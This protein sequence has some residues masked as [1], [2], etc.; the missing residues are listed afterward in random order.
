MPKLGLTMQE[1]L[2]VN[3][4]KSEGDN[5][6]K[7]ESV[8]EIETE[9][10]TNVVESPADGVLLRI[11]CAPGDSLPIASVLAYLGEAGEAVPDAQAAREEA[12]SGGAAP[13]A[14]PQA[15]GSYGAAQEGGGSSGMW[16]FPDI[17]GPGAG[18][19]SDP[20]AEWLPDHDA[21]WLQDHDA[22]GSPAGRTKASPAARA[23]AR[24]YGIDYELLTGTGPGGRIIREDVLRHCEQSKTAGRTS[25][26]LAVP[27]DVV[28]LC[29]QK[30]AAGRE[31]PGSAI[32]E[33]AVSPCGQ[34]EASPPVQKTPTEGTAITEAV[35]PYADTRKL[36]GDN[37][38]H[39]WSAI[40]MAT[41]HVKADIS[42]LVN[43][44]AQLNAGAA[45][46]AAKIGLLELFA[47]TV[48]RTI[49]D[50]PVFNSS[51]TDAGIYLHE[52]IN[53]GIAVAIRGG[54]VIPVVRD[55]GRKNI[56]TLSREIKSLSG[57]AAAGKLEPGDIG[58][59]TFTI[60]HIGPCGSVDFFTPIIN[61]PESAIL[62]IGRTVETPVVK[63]G[64]I[65]IRSMTGLSL[66]FDHRV[67]DDAPA[68]EFLAAL[69]D[70]IEQPLRAVF[71]LKE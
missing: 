70:Y 9:K 13:E 60:S 16:S 15:E 2:I 22:D 17:P 30:E 19:A 33:D 29:E 35:I 62:G 42:E 45:D 8:F 23:L 34:S 68:A 64:V 11:V 63:D 6:S 37:M 32:S 43:I 69:L 7:G 5:V 65:V 53:L 58:G 67:I 48:T 12:G 57:K 40:P 39:S 31:S 1:G 36:V 66:T 20:D 41:H 44:K 50:F 54:F 61:S 51:L 49:A 14:K 46:S 3:L 55:A 27:E 24:K 25:L 47:K 59:G 71:G 18:D 28:R 56:F 21:E 26:R 38:A 52:Q 10:L 4:L